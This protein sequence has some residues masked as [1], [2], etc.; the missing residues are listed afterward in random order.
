MTQRPQHPSSVTVTVTDYWAVY[1]S[2]YWSISKYFSDTLTVTV[3]V[4]GYLF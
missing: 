3:T 1:V 2:D 4:T